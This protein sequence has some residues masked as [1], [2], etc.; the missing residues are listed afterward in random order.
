MS[1]SFNTKIVATWN[2]KKNYQQ[3]SS[4]EKDQRN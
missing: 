2:S 1:F 4:L 3:N